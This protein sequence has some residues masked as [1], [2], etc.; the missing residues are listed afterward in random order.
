MSL[1]Y[2]HD[3][4]ALR[5]KFGLTPSP[6]PGTLEGSTPTHQGENPMLKIITGEKG[7]LIDIDGIESDA[8][9]Y[10]HAIISAGP[11]GTLYGSLITD[12]DGGKPQLYKLTPVESIHEDVMLDADE[13][14]GYIEDAMYE[15]GE[16]GEGDDAEAE[17]EGEDDDD[18]DND[19]DADD[20]IGVTNN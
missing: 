12:P 9:R 17:D 20:T 15:D 3:A 13:D 2:P 8:H 11:S 4:E 19:N 14:G 18:D 6:S 10:G 5:P 7:Y 16:D 1:R